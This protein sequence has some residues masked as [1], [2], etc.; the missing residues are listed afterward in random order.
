[1]KTTIEE[2][3]AKLKKYHGKSRKIKKISVF[4]KK[5]CTFAELYGIMFWEWEKGGVK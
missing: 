3:S 1:L 5:I 4:Q 2:K